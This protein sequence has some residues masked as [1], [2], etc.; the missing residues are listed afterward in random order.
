MATQTI[1]PF[2]SIR[3]DKDGPTPIYLQIAEAI[4][5]LLASGVLPPGYVL[6][7]ERVLCEQCLERI[8]AA[9]SRV[10]IQDGYMIGDN[11]AN[12]GVRPAPP[13]CLDRRLI[14]ACRVFIAAQVRL[15][16]ACF[17]RV[18]AEEAVSHPSE[19]VA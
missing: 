14:L 6:P 11:A 7:P 1:T 10:N 17:N 16:R 2:S 18:N 12:V 3:I 9:V 19:C 4:S 8:Q 15:F 5:S 13:P